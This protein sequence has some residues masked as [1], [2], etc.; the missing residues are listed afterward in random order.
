MATA[1]VTLLTVLFLLLATGVSFA[2]DTVLYG[3]ATCYMPE[4]IEMQQ[5]QTPRSFPNNTPAYSQGPA[6]QSPTDNEAPLA[7]GASG[8]Y[9][10]QKEIRMIQAEK[11]VSA[12]NSALG[13]ETTIYSVCAK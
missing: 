6:A 12:D 4:M 8:N 11:H 3:T 2:G 1:R 9:V 5:A 13:Q 7:S 10:V